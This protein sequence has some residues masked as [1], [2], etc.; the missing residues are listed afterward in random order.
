M[1]S[2]DVP[3]CLACDSNLTVVLILIECEECEVRQKYY[4]AENLQQFIPGNQCYRIL[5][6]KHA[7]LN[8][9]TSNF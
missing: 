2:E 7:C 1:N 3:I 9:R 6:N 5:P 8:K 4:D